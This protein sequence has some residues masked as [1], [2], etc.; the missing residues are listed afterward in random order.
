VKV[1]GYT[2][3][4]GADLRGANLREADLREADLRGANLRG[5]NLRWADLSGAN[6]RWADLRGADLRWAR[7]DISTALHAGWGVVSD[8]LCCQLMRL[9]AEAIPNGAK[10]MKEWAAG[11]ECP[12]SRSKYNRVANFR[13]RR[14]A[15]RPGRPWSLWRIWK[16]LAEERGIKI[17]GA[18]DK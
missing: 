6:L 7:Y 18:D 10:F 4:R 3:E 12:L 14:S 13:E 2:I 11:G 1:S 16:K 9:D 5:A 17:S 15:Y 8:E